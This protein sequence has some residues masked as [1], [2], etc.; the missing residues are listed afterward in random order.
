MRRC[1][2]GHRRVVEGLRL[3]EGALVVLAVAVVSFAYQSVGWSNGMTYH[4][5]RSWY[6]GLPERLLSMDPIVEF[7]VLRGGGETPVRA[8]RRWR[9]AIRLSE[10]VQLRWQIAST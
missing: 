5:M 2:E 4:G 10:G 7:V 8:V 1:C 9:E 6:L 3:H